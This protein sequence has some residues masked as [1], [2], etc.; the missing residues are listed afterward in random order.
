MHFVIS[1]RVSNKKFGLIGTAIRNHWSSY[2][3]IWGTIGRAFP[4]NSSSG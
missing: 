1:N 4:S 2:K 3:N